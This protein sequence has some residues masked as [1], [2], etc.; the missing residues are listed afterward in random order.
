VQGLLP[1]DKPPG[2]T[3]HDV[4]ARV[5]RTVGVKKVGHA[6]TLDPFASGLLLLL[7]GQATRLSELFLGMDKRYRATLRLG[8]ET[9]TLDPEG[10]VV[11]ESGAW[12]GL[13][14][15][16]I[17]A[18][19]EGFR[20]PISQ[21]PPEF[22]AKKVGGV[23]AHRRV[24]RGE[25]VALAPATVTLH[26]LALETGELPLLRL[27]L[28]CSSGFYVRALARDLGRALGVGAH[29]TELRRTSIGPLTLEGSLTWDDLESLGAV[30]GSLM[31]PA[32]A[33]GH[34]PTVEVS[35]DQALRLSQ[36][37]FLLLDGEDLPTGE[38][39]RVLLD[40][41]LVAIAHLDGAQL[42]PRKVL[43]THD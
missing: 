20:G 14:E 10:E 33:L 42:R 21:T 8:V 7:V 37:Q 41:E 13:D 16:R 4:V 12:Q 25:K 11:A 43:M 40:G 5:R 35:R 29:L 31:P 3:S 17:E 9:D 2:P 34:L 26:E 28:R 39:I 6:G 38:P 32:G 15:G 36:G 30:Q 27:S 22:S 24:R 1:V 18:A 23:A 19:L